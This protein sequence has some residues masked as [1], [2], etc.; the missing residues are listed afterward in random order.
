LAASAWAS[1]TSRGWTSAA[2]TTS[3]TSRDWSGGSTGS[4]DGGA[5]FLV[6]DEAASVPVPRAGPPWSVGGAPAD[7]ALGGTVA[8]SRPVEDMP[9]VEALAAG[10]PAVVAPP[11]AG[12]FSPSPAAPSLAAAPGVAGDASRSPGTVPDPVLPTTLDG[13]LRFGAGS[14]SAAASSSPCLISAPN[15]APG[16]VNGSSAP[17]LKE[18]PAGVDVD[19][20]GAG[21]EGEEPGLNG[22][23]RC[24][25]ASAAE[26]ARSAATATTMRRRLRIHRNLT[27]GRGGSEAPAGHGPVGLGVV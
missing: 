12:G 5:G 14:S 21:F 25:R 4:R 26:P 2:W 19:G 17:S 3:A 7:E 10:A 16:P 22:G 13:A 27:A 23:G 8:A 15:Q 9:A 1:L 6:S 18:G 20:W 11:V 24:A